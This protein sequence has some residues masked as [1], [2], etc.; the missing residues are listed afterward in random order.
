MALTSR[1][2]LAAFA[3]VAALSAGLFTA[4]GSQPVSDKDEA[5]RV[6]Q[7]FINNLTAGNYLI[8]SSLM[9]NE[10]GE[11]FLGS[12]LLAKEFAGDEFTE[13]LSGIKA[14]VKD[15][16]LVFS[17]GEVVG[18]YVT[19]V[20]VKYDSPEIKAFFGGN[21]SF[22]GENPDPMVKVNGA[23]KIG[24]EYTQLPAGSSEV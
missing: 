23:W 10:C 24:C 1:G 11:D 19:D 2:R 7:S 8:A 12:M 16:E 18:A 14:T 15:V 13:L 22:Y 6:A 3:A 5:K 9:T 21:D 4:C 20:D 17:G